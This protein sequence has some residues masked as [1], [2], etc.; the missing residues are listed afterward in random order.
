MGEDT[1]V[2]R[3]LMAKD[4]LQPY[5][6]IEAGHV[7]SIPANLDENVKIEAAK[8]LN[9]LLNSE[10][11]GLKLGLSRGIPVSNVQKQALSDAGL[12]SPL[13]IKAESFVKEMKGGTGDNVVMRD[14]K[15]RETM[16]DISSKVAFDVITPEE[17][18]AEFVERITEILDGMK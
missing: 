18:A 8:F 3:P 5:Y 11:A 17:A 4:A 7:F 9:W 10:D 6:K 2:I 15:I 16:M 1:D 13:A 14:A 12:I